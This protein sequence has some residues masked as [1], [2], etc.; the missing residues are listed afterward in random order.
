MGGCQTLETLGISITNGYRPAERRGDTV[1][2]KLPTIIEL[3]R[4]DVVSAF[5]LCGTAK[6]AKG[7]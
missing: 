7:L 4:L 1:M 5:P 6:M 2:Q 3:F